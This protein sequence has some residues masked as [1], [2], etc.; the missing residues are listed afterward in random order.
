MW[1]TIQV[2]LHQQTY[3]ISLLHEKKGYELC[4]KLN[5][6]NIRNFEIM[7]ISEVV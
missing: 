7:F 6:E 1:P 4:D 2:L 3:P 5:I